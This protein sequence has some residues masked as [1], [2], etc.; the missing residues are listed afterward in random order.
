M[1]DIPDGLRKIF[2]NGEGELRSG[3]R[4][5]LFFLI[6][7][8]IYVILISVI[9]AIGL[10]VPAIR[11]V[12]VPPDLSRPADGRAIGFTALNATLQLV[13]ALAAS[14]LCARLFERRS[15]ASIGYKLHEGWL[16]DFALGSAVG[17]ATLAISVGISTLA[18]AVHFTVQ[19][20]S[21]TLLARNFLILFVIFLIAAAFEEVLVRG[22][23]FQALLHNLGPAAA[24]AITSVTFG[25][26]HFVNP[27]ATLFSTLNTMLAGVWLA[28][29]YLMTRSLWL[30]TALHYSWNFVMVFVFGLP[31]SGI[32][33]YDH[34]V[35]L[36]G[37]PGPPVWLSGGD[38]GLEGG[39]AATLALILSTLMVW[40]SGL[41]SASEQMLR[42]V[43]HGPHKASEAVEA[44]QLDS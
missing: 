44:R 11:A 30:A 37:E 13:S 29:A 21:I 19:T 28:V 24:V 15:L 33:M 35:W 18:G 32:N 43:G 39:A 5:L 26:M 16:R 17:G 20:T 34:M 25:L 27:G 7:S 10:F 4:V 14:A 1:S 12:L 42:A 23:P 38:Y 2:I 6:F 40:K 22:F 9:A 31:V 36:D 41:F 8:V 3:W